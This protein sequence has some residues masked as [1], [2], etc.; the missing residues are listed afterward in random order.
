MIP[1]GITRSERVNWRKWVDSAEDRDYWRDIV[2]AF[3][4]KIT[5]PFL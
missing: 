3:F 5:E 1:V 2:S 4:V